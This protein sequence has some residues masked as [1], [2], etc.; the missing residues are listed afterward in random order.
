LRKASEWP[1]EETGSN[2]CRAL[3][4]EKRGWGK[5]LSCEMEAE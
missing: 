1:I 2:P 5:G 3:K 4:R